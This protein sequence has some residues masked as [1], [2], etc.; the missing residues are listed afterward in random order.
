MTM[1]KMRNE[2]KDTENETEI[3]SAYST[4]L[5]EVRRVIH[6]AYIA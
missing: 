1:E 2:V 5:I 6:Y 3:V 4:Y